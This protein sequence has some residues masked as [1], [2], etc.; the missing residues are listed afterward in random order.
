MSHISKELSR[1]IAPWINSQK[2]LASKLEISPAAVCQF[3]SGKT[4]ISLSRFLQIAHVLNLPAQEVIS[5]FNLYLDEYHIPHERMSLVF[6]AGIHSANSP[7]RRIFQLIDKLSEEDLQRVEDMLCLLTAQ[8]S[9]E[10][11]KHSAPP[12]YSS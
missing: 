9:H 7:K 1:I 6:H 10:E 8:S 2:T 4:A 11:E 3:L 12:T 5:A